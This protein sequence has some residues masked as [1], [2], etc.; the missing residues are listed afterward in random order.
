MKEKKGAVCLMRVPM[1]ND[2]K[3]I[4]RMIQFVPVHVVLKVLQCNTE[5]GIFVIIPQ[6]CYELKYHT[7][8]T[9]HPAQNTMHPSK[10]SCL[11][12]LSTGIIGLT[13]HT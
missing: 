7:Q 10:L 6:T 4:P 2:R 3:K 5:L 1:E 13:H 8:S 12:L 9:F 11:G